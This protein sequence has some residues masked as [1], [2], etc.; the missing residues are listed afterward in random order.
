MADENMSA[1]P[2]S[3]KEAVE[4]GSKFFFTGVACDLGHL[5]RRY[6]AGGACRACQIARSALYQKENSEHVNAKNSRWAAR[7]RD[8]VAARTSR[9]Q[10]ANPERAAAKVARWR[11][12]N[13]ERARANV[14]KTAAGKPDEYHAARKLAWVRANR[15]K[16][17]AI[18]CA[19]RARKLSAPGKFTAEDVAALRECQDDLCAGCRQPMLAKH[20][21][22]HIMP[23]IRGGSNWPSNTQLMCRNCNSSKNDMTM[24]EWLASRRRVDYLKKRGLAFDL[25]MDEWLARRASGTL[26]VSA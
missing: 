24:D 25:T 17:N 8:K 5:D 18:Q 13:P 4:C 6:T 10:K 19:R 26:N 9:W 7:N 1:L 22:D 3:R 15:D 21:V 16:W 20:T 2:S 23:L 14:R 12:K 11:A